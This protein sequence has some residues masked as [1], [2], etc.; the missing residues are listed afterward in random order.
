MVPNITQ[1]SKVKTQLQNLTRK[2]RNKPK[3][4]VPSRRNRKEWLL[5]IFRVK[6]KKLKKWKE[7]SNA[8]SPKSM[9]FKIR[10][11]TNIHQIHEKIMSI[12]TGSSYTKLAK[13]PSK[14]PQIQGNSSPKKFSGTF[15]LNHIIFPGKQKGVR[16]SF[17]NKP[18]FYMKEKLPIPKS[19]KIP[20]KRNDKVS[21]VP[22][23]SLVFSKITAQS[24]QRKEPKYKIA[25]KEEVTNVVL[26]KEKFKDISSPVYYVSRSNL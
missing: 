6:N 4:T 10:Q 11:G 5:E 24:K 25:P 26:Q 1:V 14:I 16:S 19:R 7:G 18:L 13:T 22:Q 17:E 3:L 8:K 21:K 12:E 15:S 20:S 9:E 23:S 2:I